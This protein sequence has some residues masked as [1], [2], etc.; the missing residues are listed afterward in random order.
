MRFDGTGY[1]FAFLTGNNRS[2]MDYSVDDQLGLRLLE[3]EYIYLGSASGEYLDGARE[4]G[5]NGIY[6]R[7]LRHRYH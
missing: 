7:K 1:D 5:E 2:V 3:G 4:L 6:L